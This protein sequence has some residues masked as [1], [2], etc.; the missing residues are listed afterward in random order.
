MPW[1]FVKATKGTS[2]KRAAIKWT[3]KGGQNSLRYENENLVETDIRRFPEKTQNIVSVVKSALFPGWFTAI[4]GVD[5]SKTYYT[6]LSTSL[7]DYSYYVALYDQYRVDCV[8]VTFWP[9]TTL[10]INAGSVVTQGLLTV[11]IDYDDSTALTSQQQ[12]LDYANCITVAG[13]KKL[14]R[15]YTPSVS[16]VVFGSVL[17]SGYAPRKRVWL[18]SANANVS[19]FGIK[20]YWS[21]ASTGSAYDL[22]VRVHYSFRAA[23]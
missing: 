15:T 9:Q 3:K 13:D 6:Q 10:D 19:C 16:A 8:E 21:G 12:A 17:G 1:K 18:D 7:G 2:R 11:V 23:R 4:T 14:T 20:A 5:Q 22:A